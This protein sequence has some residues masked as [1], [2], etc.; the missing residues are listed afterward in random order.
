MS[1]SFHPPPIVDDDIRWSCRLL[2]LPENAFHGAAGADPRAAVIKD[3]STADIAACPGSGKTTL[4][5]AKLAILV[6][7]WREPTRGICVLSHTNVARS[8]IEHGLGSCRVGQSLLQYPHYVGT[9]HGFVN[10]F[11]ALPWLRSL[12]YSVKLI[13]SEIAAERRWRVLTHNTRI[14][15][16]KVH[17]DK[18]D[19][20]A[21]PPDF[22][23]GEVSLGKS[24]TLGKETPT[25]VDLCRVCRASAQDG[26]FSHS[27]MFMWARD[28][29]AMH[30]EMIPIL[31]DRFP[32]VFVD[33]S[34]DNDDEQA[35]L[36][37]QLFCA[38]QSPVLFQ[39][40]GDANQAIFNNSDTEAPVA[41]EY[42]FPIPAIKRDLPSSHRFNQ[43]IA[44]I[45][46]PFGLVP[47]KLKGEGPKIPLASMAP[48][49][50]HTIFLFTDQS[51]AEQVL[52]RFG[53]L[54]LAT[55]NDEEL[56]RGTFKAVG[57]VTKKTEGAKF[58]AHVGHYWPNFDR[59][60]SM[61]EP[62]PA[63]FAEYISIGL[64]RSRQDGFSHSLVQMLA[65]GVMELVR[66]ENHTLVQQKRTNRYRYVCELLE[67]DASLLA[68][69]QNLVSDIATRNACTH[70][71]WDGGWRQT[72]A[73]VVAH[74]SGSPGTAETTA[75]L[76]WPVEGIAT[77]ALVG[78]KPHPN[79]YRHRVGSREAV[80][81]IGSIHS[82]KGETHTGTLVLETFFHAYNLNSIKDWLMGTKAG[83]ASGKRVN[84]RLKLHY[85]ALTR[86]THI[87]CLA[88][89]RSAFE[90]ASV[91][92]PAKVAQL[93]AK[94]WKVR[95]V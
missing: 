86:P 33:E 73:S 41:P 75:F 83:A 61:A 36:L 78:E 19:L 79:I 42:A 84:T 37:H 85:V 9:I 14:F 24:K 71:D 69:Y 92:D 58:P 26:I 18:L 40:F 16:D 51:G 80:I 52:A 28:F 68:R 25:Y 53:D 39:R 32:M 66:R 76:A 57:H 3:T 44:S 59:G 55:F 29:L 77:T 27:E 46:D 88:M 49:A 11:L 15:L 93:E 5:V 43:R 63:T 60:Y 50:E 4:L 91:L 8:E 30:P 20:V 10:E 34:Q 67:T 31:R 7:K 47:Y 54:L 21:G 65:D 72:I 74:I 6:S 89:H 13:D 1:G 81:Q 90:T 70:A 94:G 95:L 62:R 82:V 35:S 22:T 2:G 56:R 64:E 38:G 48:D 87:V 12:G 45:A 17:F 23:V